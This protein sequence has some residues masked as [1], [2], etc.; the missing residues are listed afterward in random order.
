MLTEVCL[1][2]FNSYLTYVNA[3][4]KLWVNWE[5]IFHFWLLLD[6]VFRFST[7]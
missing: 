7:I 4:I 5:F 1:P 3:I 2:I 6:A